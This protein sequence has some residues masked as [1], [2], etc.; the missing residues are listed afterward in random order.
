MWSS[1]NRFVAGIWQTR[2]IEWAGDHIVRDP[3]ELP[4][5]LLEFNSARLLHSIGRYWRVI[6][7][8]QFSRT[9]H[10]LSNRPYALGA[11]YRDRKDRDSVSERQSKRAHLERHQLACL[12]ASAL[13]KHHQRAA[14]S[15]QLDRFTLRRSVGGSVQVHRKSSE[16]SHQQAK[17]RNLKWLVPGHVVNSANYGNRD[18]YRI[19]VGHVIW[20][21]DARAFQRDV[22]D[23]IKLNLEH[24]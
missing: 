9:K 6:C 7:D 1:R 10:E 19:S 24:D 17:P 20:R 15:K 5:A 13:R 4:R 11:F 21:D 18:P 14:A 3:C 12:C 8:R 2:L 16:H 23:S 22:L